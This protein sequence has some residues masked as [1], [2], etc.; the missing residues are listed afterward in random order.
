MNNRNITI[1][2]I[3]ICM[4]IIG[5]SIVLTDHQGDK[6]GELVL[7][8]GFAA[9]IISNLIKLDSI[10]SQVD[11]TRTT[12]ENVEKLVNGH[13]DALKAENEQLKVDLLTMKGGER[14]STGH[15]YSQ[16]EF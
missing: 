14:R 16:S 9:P 1:A 10:G 7:L 13:L 2:V 11:K 8:I 12:N 6:A 5:G 4:I 3:S 15:E